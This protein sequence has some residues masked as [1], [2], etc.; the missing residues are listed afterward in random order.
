ML[1]ANPLCGIVEILTD[2]IDADF[3]ITAVD[4]HF[5]SFIVSTCCDTIEK[6]LV[7]KLENRAML[8]V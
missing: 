5:K 7:R 8:T 1:L 4:F 2:T 3:D 6:L